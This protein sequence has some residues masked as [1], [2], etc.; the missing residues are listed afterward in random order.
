MAKPEYAH[1]PHPSPHTERQ[2]PSQCLRANT[3]RATNVRGDVSRQWQEIIGPRTRGT[4]LCSS[5]EPFW[6]VHPYDRVGARRGQT[7][8]RKPRLQ[9]GSPHL[10][11]AAC[12]QWVSLSKLP[13]IATGR[14]Q[15]SRQKAKPTTKYIKPR[16][17]CQNAS[18]SAVNAGV[19]L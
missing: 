1:Q 17:S 14:L 5:E 8:P 18:K 3:C 16:R 12:S 15:T 11:R 2:A 6:I 7:H 13:K 10:P 9:H 4:C 19:Q